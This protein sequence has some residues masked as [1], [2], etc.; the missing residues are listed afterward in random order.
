VG[1]HVI[2]SGQSRCAVMRLMSGFPLF[3]GVLQKLKAIFK[4]TLTNLE[5]YL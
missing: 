2:F 4:L 5:F 1:L 3:T